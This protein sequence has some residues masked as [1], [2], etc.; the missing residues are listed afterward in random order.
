M[1]TKERKIVVIATNNHAEAMRV[2]A[3]LTIYCHEI[4]M[5]FVDKIVEES[6]ENIAQAELLELCEIEPVSILDDPN[7]SKISSEELATLIN[8][9]DKVVSL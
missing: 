9:A 2:A 1:S 3:G 4:S 5:I 8:K 6:E 7:M